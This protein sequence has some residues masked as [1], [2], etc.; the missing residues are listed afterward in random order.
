MTH[1]TSSRFSTLKFFFSSSSFSTHKFNL[2]LEYI[3]HANRRKSFSL[4][5]SSIICVSRSVFFLVVVFGRIC[6]TLMLSRRVV[7]EEWKNKRGKRRWNRLSECST[8][9]LVSILLSIEHVYSHNFSLD[10]SLFP[11]SLSRLLIFDSRR[12][13]MARLG[14]KATR[15][16]F[17]DRKSLFF[18]RHRTHLLPADAKLWVASIAITQRGGP[19]EHSSSHPQMLEIR[20][21]WVDTVLERNQRHRMLLCRWIWRRNRWNAHWRRRRESQL[22]SWLESLSSCFVSN[23][24]L[25]GLCSWRQKRMS[26]LQVSRSLRWCHLSQR[27]SMWG[28]RDEM[29]RRRLSTAANVQKAEKF[30]WFVSCWSATFDRWNNSTF[31]LRHGTRQASV[32]AT[33]QVSRSAW[34]RLRRL[35]SFIA[36]VREARNMSTR[37]SSNFDARNWRPLRI[38]VRPRSRVSSITEMLRLIGLRSFVST[39]KWLDALSSGKIEIGNSRD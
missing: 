36:E 33:L 7:V 39:A 16:N 15:N 20:S 32:S 38:T 34:Q 14:K 30:E 37:R 28:D 22:L 8:F 11:S 1:W 2:E 18:S 21:V 9:S 12:R 17:I 35:L 27:S 4:S 19:R 31:P 3:L 24:L 10:S 29:Q 25:F 6:F 26:C 13:R 23:V 5:I